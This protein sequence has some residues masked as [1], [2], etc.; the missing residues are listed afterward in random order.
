MVIVSEQ[1]ICGDCNL[2]SN[3]TITKM[4]S[5][6]LLFTLLIITFFTIIESVDKSNFKTCEQSGFCKRNRNLSQRPE[7]FQLIDGTIVPE[8]DYKSVTFQLKNDDTGVIYQAQ[9]QSILAGQ[10]FR[11]RVDE[12]DSPK[13]RFDP[14]EL[15]LMPNIKGTKMN[16]VDQSSDGFTVET[17]DEKNRQKNKIIVHANPFRLD[18]YSGNDLVMVVNQRGLFNFEH[19]RHK[20]QGLFQR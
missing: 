20:P 10:T 15:V 4:N 3:K 12:I 7:R 14:S 2:I 8:S 13:K 1:N 16:I 5:K 17:M 9:L 18:V 19:F 11:F 6:S